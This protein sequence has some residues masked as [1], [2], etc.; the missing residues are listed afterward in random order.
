MAQKASSCACPCY[1]DRAAPECPRDQQLN[2][3]SAMGMCAPKQRCAP[4]PATLGNVDR[5]T[6]RAQLKDAKRI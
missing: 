6:Y 1:R 5:D 2:A 4:A 3:Q